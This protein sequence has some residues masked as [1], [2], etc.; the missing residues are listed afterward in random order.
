[1]V[2]LCAA[3][4][5]TFVIRFYERSVSTKKHEELIYKNSPKAQMTRLVSFGPV[6]VVAAFPAM[7]FIIRLYERSVG[8]KKNM[9]N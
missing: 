8:T 1:M 5:V 6:F 3:Y 9:K 7:Y 4:F 2:V